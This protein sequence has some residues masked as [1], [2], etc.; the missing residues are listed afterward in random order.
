MQ[1]TLKIYDQMHTLTIMIPTEHKLLEI[2]NKNTNI[3]GF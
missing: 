1:Q 2:A 3:D